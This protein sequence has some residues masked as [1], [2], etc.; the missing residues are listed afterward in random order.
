MEKNGQ[1]VSWKDLEKTNCK[2][3]RLSSYD[4]IEI[5]AFIDKTISK[6]IEEEEKKNDN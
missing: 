5:A 4:P 2:T 6:G 1:P 3:V